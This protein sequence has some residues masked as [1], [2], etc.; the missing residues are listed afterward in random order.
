LSFKSILIL[1]LVYKDNFIIIHNS[2]N[3]ELYNIIKNYG[4]VISHDGHKRTK[5]TIFFMRMIVEDIALLGSKGS[6]SAEMANLP[7]CSSGLVI[8]TEFVLNFANSENCC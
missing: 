4:D 3:D 1:G 5:T 7:S 6:A 8:A 2:N